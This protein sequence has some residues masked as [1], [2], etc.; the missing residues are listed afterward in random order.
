MEAKGWFVIIVWECELKKGAVEATISRV[1]NEI[2]KNGEAL[3]KDISERRRA[4]E[5]YRK[6]CRERKEREEKLLAEISHQ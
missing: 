4:R 3:Q 6:S 5:E 1:Q 2:L